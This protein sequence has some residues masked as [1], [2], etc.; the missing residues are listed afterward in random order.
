MQKVFFSLFI[1]SLFH[2]SNVCSSS[3]ADI[4]T[5]LLTDKTKLFHPLI[6]SHM[7]VEH[8]ENGLNIKGSFSITYSGVYSV[9]M[10]LSFV[11]GYEDRVIKGMIWPA[12]GEEKKALIDEMGFQLSSSMMIVDSLDS[13]LNYVNKNYE[14]TVGPTP[15]QIMIESAFSSPEDVP[16]ERD[17]QIHFHIPYIEQNYLFFE[18]YKSINFVIKRLSSISY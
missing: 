15:S 16:K 11:D 7:D 2:S 1:L 17:I 12:E 10:F 8:K 13:S 4:T 5:E 9:Y 6:N 18:R 3:L 14:F